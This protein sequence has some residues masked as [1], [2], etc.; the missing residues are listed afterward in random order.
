[1]SE[2]GDSFFLGDDVPQEVGTSYFDHKASEAY[3]D[4]LRAELSANKGDLKQAKEL[5]EQVEQS[6]FAHS[7]TLTESLIR[8]Y[9]RSGEL[10][11]ALV[12]VDKALA[13]SPSDVELLKLKAGILSALKRNVEAIEVYEQVI[14]LEPKASEEIYVLI[15]NLYA[16][17][18]LVDSAKETLRRLIAQSPKS[19]IG[20]YYYG[21]ISE[22]TNQY[23]EA[24]KNYKL[25]LKYAPDA[26]TMN[27]DIARV[28]G[29]KEDYKE[30]VAI[31]NQ[32]IAKSPENIAARKLL[33]Q[34]LL[35]E[36]KVEDA[37]KE[38]QIV[39]SLEEDATD[40][41][42][43]IALIQLQ[44]KQF[45]AAEIE[46]SLVL[47]QQPNSGKVRYY[48]ATSLVGQKKYEKAIEELRK[49]S[50][51][52]DFYLENQIFLAYLLQESKDLKGAIA[53]LEE[54]L[55]GDG[56]KL[57]AKLLAFLVSLQKE[58]GSLKDA[59][60]TQKRLIAIDDKNDS[61]Y[62]SLGV[63]YDEAGETKLA[64][65][66]MEKAIELNPNHANALNYL[67]YTLSVKNVDLE[68]A[69]SLVTRALEIEPD[70]G[71]FVDSLG[72]I[73]Y[74]MGKYEEAHLH[75]SRAVELVP[76]DAVILEHLGL[77]QL[78]LERP[79]LAMQVLE[80]ALEYAPHSD[81]KEAAKRIKKVLDATRN[82]K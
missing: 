55:K 72:W 7:K 37:L 76:T 15:A 53:V 16:Q 74:Q 73:Y 10:E 68:R 81:D 48:L 82:S 62:F 9:V 43:K 52:Q 3:Y 17:Q 59:V 18:N 46:L 6:G 79:D 44:K 2:V 67:G 39:G 47:Q 40:T 19:F 4:F 24:I 41:R 23:D 5:Y 45:E 63:L 8:L 13:D 57:N 38:L 69:I 66:A 75:L 56:Q 14:L 11:K 42:F 77:C 30:A 50:P 35:S 12:Q 64:I 22:L 49:A 54:I 33:G 78:K 36:N 31:V 70:N 27:L 80:K 25:A 51:D 34:L 60:A 26:T 58:A 20:Y 29:L 71:Y 65:D 32:I 1:M 21:R 28:Y 61:Y